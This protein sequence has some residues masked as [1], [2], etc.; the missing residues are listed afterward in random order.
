MQS[1]NAHPKSGASWEGF[2]LEVIIDRLRL[3]DEHVHFWAAHT[4]AKLDLM[5]T[6]GGSRI[7]VEIKQTTAPRV[8]PSIRAALH[9]LGPAEVI[10]VHAGRE[11]GP[12][13]PNVRAVAANRL[14]KDLGL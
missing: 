12:L 10:L 4:G 14:D 8:T 2:L 5:I 7:G 3:E 6:R 13:G 9:D 11:S 1:L